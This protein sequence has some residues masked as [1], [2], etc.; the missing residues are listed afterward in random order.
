M[1][2]LIST[3]LI[4][5]AMAGISKASTTEVIFDPATFTGT[6]P[7]GMSIIDTAGGKYLRVVL[8][9][10]NSNLT[11]PE[12]TISA[13]ANELTTVMFKTNIIVAKGTY[14]G[15]G[16][17][18]YANFHAFVQ[19]NGPGSLS[20]NCGADG[21]TAPTAIQ[22]GTKAGLVNAVQFAIQDKADGWN[23]MVGAVIYVGKIETYEDTP[24][25][26]AARVS[27]SI[28][29]GSPV[30]DGMG[31]DEIWENANV[32]NIDQQALPVAGAT[33]SQASSGTLR[34]LWD[35]KNLYILVEAN[36]PGMTAGYKPAFDATT[37]AVLNPWF[38][39]AI[40]LFIDIK[41]RRYDGARLGDQLQIRMSV[42]DTAK[43]I[44]DKKVIG[45]KA[46]KYSYLQYLDA[47][48][49]IIEAT[50][51]W[52][53]LKAETGYVNDVAFDGRNLSFEVSI[54]NGTG[55]GA[56][57]SRLS[58]MNWAN[59]Q[60]DDVAYNTSKY[61][62]QLTLVGGT[63]VALN[64][65]DGFKMFPNPATSDVKVSMNNLR[66]VEVFDI[67]G[68]LVTKQVAS[69]NV[70]N[71]NVA[72]VK[73]GVYFVKVYTDKGFAGVSKLVKN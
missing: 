37:G 23:A 44:S 33:P 21:A 35:A 29:S 4:C 58:I 14:A 18:D 72:S 5:L 9:G 10:W 39:D 19:P 46:G 30:V 73:A 25:N 13:A 41:N 43:A 42:G 54:I 69:S 16:A 6:L 55:T 59:N 32:M 62:G 17:A 66:S 49:W 3:L 2:K 26:N 64:A 1:R 57:G 15:A 28:V 8:D 60:K 61:W 7:A 27:Y 56:D 12:V 63:A 45:I 50:L 47:G 51:P 71:I 65:A 36:D 38:Q 11:I 24:T 68:K 70:A 31:G 22:G 53:S 48:K 34:A 20:Y 52:D 40:E 67:T